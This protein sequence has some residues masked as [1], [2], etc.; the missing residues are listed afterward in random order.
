MVLF[1][2]KIEIERIDYLIE[3]DKLERYIHMKRYQ[4]ALKNCKEGTILDL[5]CG[6]GWGT[7]F[8]SSKGKVVGL[9]VDCKIIQDAER[10]YGNKDGIEF[11]CAD[12]ISI[13]FENCTFDCIISLE[14][15]E[16]VNNQQKYLQ[17]VHRTLKKDGILILSTPNKDR[18]TIRLARLMRRD[19]YQ[20]PYHFHEFNFEELEEAF[21]ENNFELLFFN[22]MYLPLLPGNIQLAKKI[23]S[24]FGIYKLCV[25]MKS[26]KFRQYLADFYLVAKKK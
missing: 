7:N 6:L 18:I 5:G 9:D 14:N 19:S 26:T 20:N 2:L 4:I 17:E 23:R 8:L 21:K 22:G 24:I 10:R 13:P 16:H 1:K 15:I 11:I 3:E 12:A 25:N